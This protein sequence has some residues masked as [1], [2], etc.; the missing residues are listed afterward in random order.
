ME[1]EFPFSAAPVRRSLVSAALELQV[2]G[3][4]ISPYG[5]RSKRSGKAQCDGCSS[6]GAMRPFGSAIRQGSLLLWEDIV[7]FGI[8]LA[9]SSHSW[10]VVKC[11][12]ELGFTHAW[13]YD[14][15]LLN[16]DR[17]V[18]MGAAAVKT[19]RIRLGTGVLIPSN[20]IAPVAA[21]AVAS[22]HALA[23]GRIEFGVVH[24]VPPRPP[25]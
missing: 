23:P 2:L 9:T 25:L 13:F 12:E 10:R 7:D 22:L 21:G 8:Q 6:L 14:T 16:A 1:E 19:S 5:A 17:F 20:R 11:A 18:A 4:P 15:Q 24:G 3:N